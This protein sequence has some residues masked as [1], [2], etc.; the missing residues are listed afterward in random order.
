[1]PLLTEK[2]GY[3]SSLSLLKILC[4]LLIIVHHTEYFYGVL[5]RGYIAVEFFFVVSGYLMIRKHEL[6][7]DLTTLQYTKARIRRLF[8][9]YLFAL[10]AVVIVRALILCDSPYKHWYSPMVEMVMLQNVGIPLPHESANYP[11]WYLSVLFY[12]SILIIISNII[13]K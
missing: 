7:S 13:I 3:N 11:C 2:H 12:G 10:A 8:P 5:N 4:T 1:M 6:Q 9:E